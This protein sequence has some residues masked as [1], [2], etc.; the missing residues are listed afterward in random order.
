M[1]FWVL[2]ILAVMV[3]YGC[4]IEPRWFRIVHHTI[5][6]NKRLPRPLKILHLSDMHFHPHTV[7]IRP[8]MER[9]SL[10]PDIDLILISGD[11]IDIDNGI[12]LAVEELKKFHPRLGAYVVFG[13]H[14]HYWYGRREFLKFIFRRVFPRFPNNVAL[15]KHALLALKFRVL[16]NEAATIP[17]EGA[18]IYIAGLDDPVTFRERP[19]RVPKP[20]NADA[21][22]ILLSHLIDPLLRMKDYGFDLAFSGH[23]HGGQWRLP[24]IGPVFTDSLVHRRY[25]EGLQWM[26]GTRVFTS[27]GVGHSPLLPARFFCRPEAAVFTILSHQLNKEEI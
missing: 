22:K 26:D 6:V 5:R 20:E 24:G 19:E 21:L 23:T 4:V 9:L 12:I 16:I 17:F 25:S 1:I 8:F 7:Y 11:T 2:L 13:N 14:D 18:E 3:V 27:R 10:I 15:L